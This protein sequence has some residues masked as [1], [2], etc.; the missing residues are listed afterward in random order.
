M[1][2][3]DGRAAS[4]L[5]RLLQTAAP[6]T[7][8]DGSYKF[9]FGPVTVLAA[10]TGPQESRLRDEKPD[11]ATLDVHVLPLRGLAS[12]ATK[13]WSAAIQTVLSELVQLHL[14]P[15]ALLSVT[16]QTLVLP[17]V[18]YRRPFTTFVPSD[19]DGEGEDDEDGLEAA[20]SCVQGAALLNAAVGG[21]LEA[22]WP[23]QGVATAVGLAKLDGDWLLDPTAQEE[24]DA[25][26]TLVL[27]FAFGAAFGGDQGRMVWCET[28]K[29]KESIAEDD[30]S[31]VSWPK[32]MRALAD[33]DGTDAICDWHGPSRLPDHCAILPFLTCAE[34]PLGHCQGRADHRRS[35]NLGI[36]FECLQREQSN[37]SG[38]ASVFVPML[39]S[40]QHSDRTWRSTFYRPN[41]KRQTGQTT[42]ISFRLSICIRG[43]IHSEAADARPRPLQ[44]KLCEHHSCKSWPCTV[45]GD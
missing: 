23:M 15:R 29:A 39:G 2:R 43:S 32:M 26:V 28:T 20:V 41:S 16:L 42:P 35:N 1:T 31:F 9:Q 11:R 36:R 44:C 25:P 30:V 34:V 19:S 38:L 7:R 37:S 13:T 22:G 21:C 24:H 14:Y 6:I 40:Q 3:A 5:R 8:A 12:P 18:Q 17:D 33:N 45:L 27:A 10:A 4:G